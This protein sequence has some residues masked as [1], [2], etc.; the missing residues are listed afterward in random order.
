MSNAFQ[1]ISLS[2][3]HFSQFPINQSKLDQSIR[4]KR[5]KWNEKEINQSYNQQS[6]IRVSWQSIKWMNEPTNWCCF[7]SISINLS[8]L[9]VDFISHQTINLWLS[10]SEWKRK[11]EKVRFENHH[12]INQNQS[13]NQS[14][15]NQKSIK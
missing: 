14:Q 4:K 2:F 12:Q 3:F 6:Q 13:I 5:D 9:I 7:D 1:F 8:Q 11:K 15:I 10:V